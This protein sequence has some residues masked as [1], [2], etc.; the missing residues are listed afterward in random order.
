MGEP[1]RAAHGE[2]AHVALVHSVR[3]A[4]HELVAGLGYAALT[5]GHCAFRAVRVVDLREELRLGGHKIM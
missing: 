5:G 4:V 1:A 3:S 2:P